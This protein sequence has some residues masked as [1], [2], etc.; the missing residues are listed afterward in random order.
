MKKTFKTSFNEYWLFESPM[1]S[2]HSA[3][4]PYEDLVYAI[5]EN[6]KNG[7]QIINVSAVLKKLVVNSSVIYW[8]EHNNIIDIV[9]EFKK[10]PD[11]LYVEISG[12]RQGS[13]IYASDFYKMVLQD[14]SRL[15]FSGDVISDQGFG[16]WKQLINSGSK[17][18][19]YNTDNALDRT[20]VDSEED[21]LKYFQGSVDYKKYRF[22]VSESLKEHT[23]VKTSFDLL[24][25]Y[26]LTHGVDLFGN[27][28]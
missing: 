9:T 8:I 3:H 18:F 23:V 25:T 5:K 19:V 22:V 15:I 16:I 12:K 2:G 28:I 27:K 4:N 20:T 17:L 24:R 13:P 10:V 11:G 1:A 26:I 6:I 7:Q 14:S 21:L